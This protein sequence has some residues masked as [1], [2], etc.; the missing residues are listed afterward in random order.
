MML[1]VFLGGSSLIEGVAIVSACAK[2]LHALKTD[3]FEVDPLIVIT[4]VPFQT[5]QVLAL[6]STSRG[7]KFEYSFEFPSASRYLTWLFVMTTREVH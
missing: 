3:V 2:V 6:A 4:S 1:L 5:S 7:T